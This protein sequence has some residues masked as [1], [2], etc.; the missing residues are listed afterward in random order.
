MR[1]TK[2]QS[3]VIRRTGDGNAAVEVVIC[4]EADEGEQGFFLHIRVNLADL[5][6]TPM[7]AIIARALAEAAKTASAEIAKLKPRRKPTLVPVTEMLL[8]GT[9]G[10]RT[11]RRA[12]GRFGF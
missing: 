2:V 8:S 7:R 10:R 5:D 3:S 6:K 11:K 9:G 1:E 12:G 4:D